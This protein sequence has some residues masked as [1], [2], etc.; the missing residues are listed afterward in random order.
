MGPCERFMILFYV[1]LCIERFVDSS[2][3]RFGTFVVIFILYS[4]NPLGVWESGL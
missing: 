4:N 2:I 1:F 3:Y